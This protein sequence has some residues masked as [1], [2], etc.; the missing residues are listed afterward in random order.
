[1]ENSL[2]LR[3]SALTDAELLKMADFLT[4]AGNRY[5]LRILFFLYEVRESF[6]IDIADEIGLSQGTVSNH[7]ILLHGA[8]F[9]NRRRENN[10]VYYSL[11]E[12]GKN[13]IKFLM[14]FPCFLR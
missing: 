14:R 6:V 5:R 9:L 7:L 11:T 1:M 4:A 8:G 3:D 10:R 13:F 12:K 2:L